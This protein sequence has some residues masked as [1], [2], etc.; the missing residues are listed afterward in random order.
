MSFNTHDLNRNACMLKGPL[1]YNGYDWW[2]HS[3]TGHNEKTGE[4]RSFFIEFFLCNP[5]FGGSMPILGQIPFNRENGIK[6]SYL[7]VKAGSWGK[8]AKQIHRFFGWR[9]VTVSSNA[10]YSVMAADC[11]ASDF[12]LRGNVSLSVEDCATHPEY[13]C[14]PG[15]M[16]WDLKLDKQI[17][18]NVGYGASK[19]FRAAQAFDMYWH[20]EG[21]RTAYSGEVT[22]EGEKYIVD[23][24]TCY[25]YA[26]KNWGRDFTSPWIWLSSSDLFSNL[27]GKELKDSVFDIGGGRPVIAGKALDGKLLSAFWYEGQA[28][29]FNFS[30]PAL[31]TQTRFDCKETETEVLWHIAQTSAYGKIECRIR[32]DKS[33]MIL[34]N[35]ESPDGRKRHN[36]LWNGGTGKGRIKLYG[37]DDDGRLY[38]VDDIRAEKVGCEYGVYGK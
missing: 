29:E 17:A 31:F 9:D 22:Y 36:R 20:A 32:C 13:M 24:E 23:P 34:V 26:D 7:M 4:E 14:D 35:Y 8:G 25:G 3:F 30:K 12:V 16:S 1:R 28:Y 2:W 27:T 38:L 37:R 6:P 10:P 19:P 15:E 5:A 18:F 21:M 11:F 33:E